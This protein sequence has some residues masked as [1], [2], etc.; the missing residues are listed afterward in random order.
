MTA[1]EASVA[2]GIWPQ[3]C[4]NQKIATWSFNHVFAF[5]VCLWTYIHNTDAPHRIQQRRCGHRWATFPHTTRSMEELTDI[6]PP[7]P[8]A[9]KIHM[10][11]PL[12]SCHIDTKMFFSH[13]SNYEHFMLKLQSL[14]NS[15]KPSHEQFWNTAAIIPREK[16]IT[17]A[18]TPKNRTASIIQHLPA[19]YHN[20]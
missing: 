6:P 14:Q 19:P 1:L 13:R 7:P 5:Y 4:L 12:L 16:K 3:Y 9:W 17:I 11:G 2:I 8:S 20:T 15:Q 18:N 10:I